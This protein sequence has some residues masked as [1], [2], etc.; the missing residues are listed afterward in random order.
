MTTLITGGAGFVGS[1]VAAKLL[2]RG[3]RVVAVDNFNDYYDPQLKRANAERLGR[4]E[5]ATVIEADIRR[6]ASLAS[7][8][9]RRWRASA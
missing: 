3:E 6:T 1:H 5:R 9:W 4:H 2:E 8:T 7:A